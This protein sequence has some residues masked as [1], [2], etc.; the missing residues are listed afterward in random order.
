MNKKSNSLW[1]KVTEKEKEQIRKDSKKLLNEFA[2]KL[3]KIKPT[4]SYFENATGTRDE[5]NGWD[6]DTEFRSITFANAPFIE[7][8]S[9][10]AEK[11]AW[12]K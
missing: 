6:T 9:I 5:S 2:S 7:G 12:K 1:H 11:G 8:N 10:V 3:S 4:E